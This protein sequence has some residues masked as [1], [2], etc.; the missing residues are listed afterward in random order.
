LVYISNWGKKLIERYYASCGIDKLLFQL[1]DD[2]PSHLSSE[3]GKDAEFW[4]KEL[5]D[6]VSK[7]HRLSLLDGA[8]EYAVK[9]AEN[10][11]E[12]TGAG[13]CEYL[14]DSIERN[15]IGNWLAGYICGLLAG[16]YGLRHQAMFPDCVASRRRMARRMARGS[17]YTHSRET[18]FHGT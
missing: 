13:L 18:A 10:L 15:W 11:S 4:Q 1:I 14:G 17:R 7:I 8:I 9:L 5:D 16:Y 3:L 2:L 12:K 6:P